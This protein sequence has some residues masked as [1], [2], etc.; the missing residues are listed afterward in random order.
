MTKRSRSNSSNDLEITK[1]IKIIDTYIYVRV[2]TASQ[3]TDNQLKKCEEY[4]KENNISNYEIVSETCSAFKGRQ[5]KLVNLLEKKDI[6][7]I[8]Y[9]VDRLSRN[10]EIGNT[11][12]NKMINNNIKLTSLSENISIESP[13]KRH[14]IRNLIS[15]GQLES[16]KISAR[17]SNIVLKNP[18]KKYGSD[19]EEIKIINFIL[20]CYDKEMTLDKLQSRFN[21]IC[22]DD[23]PLEFISDGETLLI[24]K[25]V[26]SDIFNDYNI[27]KKNRKF[28]P[29]MIKYLFT[30]ALTGFSSLKI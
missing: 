21:I 30:S 8:I 20:Y 6:N 5:L 3:D 15:Q 4:C 12:I 23:T 2:S 25:Y 14:E 18:R 26:I 27:K 24:N 10:V 13:L 16:E 9:A 17:V 22:N 7:I 1:K 29:S 28:T 19:P 11:F